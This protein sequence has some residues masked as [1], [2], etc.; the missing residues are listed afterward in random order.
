[1]RYQGIAA[2]HLHNLTEL[3]AQQLA[4]PLPSSGPPFPSLSLLLLQT[5]AH[6]LPFTSPRLLGFCFVFC[7]GLVPC[8]GATALR[9]MWPC[10][11]DKSCH[12]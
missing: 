5:F 12:V 2:R 8:P 7:C 3:M 6:Q 11:L 10:D 9:H 1:M 4:P